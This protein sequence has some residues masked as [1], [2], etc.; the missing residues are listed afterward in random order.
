VGLEAACD[1]REAADQQHQ[2]NQGVE[3]AQRP[4]IDVQIGDDAGE[5]EERATDGEEPANLASSA[6]EE[7]CDSEKHGQEGDAEGVSSVEVPVGTD[8]GNLVDEQVSAG[9]GHDESESKLAEAAGRSASVSK[10]TFFHGP[11]YSRG[12]A[13]VSGD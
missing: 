8:D 2:Q 11:K 4:E 12:L 10:R 9:A 5:D 13:G 3:E 1:Q 6:P 7:Q